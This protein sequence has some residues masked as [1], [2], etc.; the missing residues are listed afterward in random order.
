MDVGRLEL[1]LNKRISESVEHGVRGD[2]GV[3]LGCTSVS[4]EELCAA[5]ATFASRFTPSRTPNDSGNIRAQTVLM[6]KSSVDGVTRPTFTLSL[7][8]PPVTMQRKPSLSNAL[9]DVRRAIP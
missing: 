2:D 4:D 9:G 8:R 5:E 1:I 7:S 3:S 6:A